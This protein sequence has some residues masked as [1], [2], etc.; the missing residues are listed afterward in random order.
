M[1]GSGGTQIG[2]CFSLL[3]WSGSIT[4]PHDAV[5]EVEHASTDALSEFTDALAARPYGIV[6]E[7]Q[8][9]LGKFPG[10]PSP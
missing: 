8:T 2:K 5:V 10:S 1:V 7:A 9:V 6:A 4:G 3:S